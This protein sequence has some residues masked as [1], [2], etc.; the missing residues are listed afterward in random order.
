MSH[1]GSG[2]AA[3]FAAAVLTAGL[4]GVLAAAAPA[5]A[6]SFVY[7]SIEPDACL[8][9]DVDHAYAATACRAPGDLTLVLADADIRAVVSFVH[10]DWTET[11]SVRAPRNGFN[12]LPGPVVEWR[13]D[14]DGRPTALIARLQHATDDQG[15]TAD[16]LLVIRVDVAD[17]TRIC[18]I[19][20]IAQ[21]PGANA[22]ARRVAAEAAQADCVS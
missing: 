19:A 4:V 17:P 8:L 22:E 1:A 11:A 10:P 2:R 5:H 9:I 20:D 18:L 15:G 13:L 12:W 14:G 6:Q 3:G 16:A 7:S 21:R